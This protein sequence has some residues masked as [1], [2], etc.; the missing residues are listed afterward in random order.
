M[1]FKVNS[2]LH[3]NRKVPSMHIM[4]AGNV[5]NPTVPTPWS[6]LQFHEWHLQGVGSGVQDP[7][8]FGL[9]NCLAEPWGQF[10]QHPWRPSNSP[11]PFYQLGKQK[12][13]DI[14]KAAPR[15]RHGQGTYPPTVW[16]TPIFLSWWCK[17][18]QSEGREDCNLLSRNVIRWI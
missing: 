16:M 14:K 1:K 17:L 7:S 3:S 13:L 2:L 9:T 12:K 15:E 4:S 18:E 11:T 10:R 6:Y 5:F 8:T